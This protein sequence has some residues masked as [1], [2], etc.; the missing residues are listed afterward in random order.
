MAVLR[1][2]LLALVATLT[3]AC[4]G[5]SQPVTGRIYDEF[6]C[7][8]GCAR[9][10]PEAWCISA[11]YV[12]A[13]VPACG[14]TGDCSGGERCVWVVGY[15]DTGVC[16]VADKLMV[17]HQ[18]DCQVVAHCRDADTALRALPATFSACGLEAV[19]CDSGC[20][21]TTGDCK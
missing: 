14:D 15:D 3:L 13:C 16:L 10:P 19:H 21:P 17:C 11:P 4:N 7:Q 9:C 18:P 6:G 20:D 1:P 8:I 2:A 12:P 5:A